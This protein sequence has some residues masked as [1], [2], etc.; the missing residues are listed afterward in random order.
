MYLIGFYLC[1]PVAC[2]S[3]K[4]SR[5]H[6]IF[7]PILDWFFFL[8][9][10][11]EVWIYSHS[12]LKRPSFLECL[13]LTTLSRFVCNCVDL[14]LGSLS[15]SIGLHFLRQFCAVYITV[16]LQCN[17]NQFCDVSSIALVVWG[18]CSIMWIL[19]FFLVLKRMPL[20]FSIGIM[21]NL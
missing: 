10:E 4:F 1:F 5:L 2:S 20:E 21:L 12:L 9:V 16:A 17:L 15:Y 3:F 13:F 14:F 18:L 7:D 8:C 19:G 6:Y 11:W